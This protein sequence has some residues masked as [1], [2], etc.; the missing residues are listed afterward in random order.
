M[1]LENKIAVPAAI[2]AAKKTGTGFPVP[3]FDLLR[4]ITR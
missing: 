2:G 3:A 1:I 4:R